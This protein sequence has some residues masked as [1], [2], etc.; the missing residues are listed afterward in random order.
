MGAIQVKNVPE[1][2]HDEL[3]QRA[4]NEGTNISEY[5]LRLIRRELSLPT[6]DQWFAMLK[7]NPPLESKATPDVV[8][9][10]GDARGARD[11]HIAALIDAEPP[12]RE[13]SSRGK[14]R[15]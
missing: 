14:R 2:L 6:T 1:D 7:A 5:V 13:E 11:T 9:E 10:I 4:E 12:N 8:A 15:R 3:R